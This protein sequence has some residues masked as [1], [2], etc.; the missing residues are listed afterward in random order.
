MCRLGINH[1]RWC[2]CFNSELFLHIDM[3]ARTYVRTY[4]RTAAYAPNMYVCTAYLF[5]TG[6]SAGTIHCSLL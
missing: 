5:S 4:V 6:E 3:E 1:S 2:G